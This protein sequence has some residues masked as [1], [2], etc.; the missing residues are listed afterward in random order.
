MKKYHT[1][2][3]VTMLTLFKS[4]YSQS[5]DEVNKKIAL[6]E[7][8]SVELADKQL[9]AYNNKDIDEFL[10]PFSDSVKVREYPNT[11]LY[12]GKSEMRKRYEKLFAI[13]PKLKCEIA[14]RIVFGNKVIDLE[15]L[16]GFD[17]SG[18]FPDN[19]VM[20][21]LVVYTI[22]NDLISEVCFVKQL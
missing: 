3:F 17:K 1:I 21:V 12:V 22:T 10:R 20:D 11:M 14:N 16:T 13:H 7:K 8:V 5:I 15:K 9:L 19:W 2:L 18:G 6:L 4:A